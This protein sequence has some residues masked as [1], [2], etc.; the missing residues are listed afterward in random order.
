MISVIIPAYNA[1]TTLPRCI[2]SILAQ[3]YTGQFEI[4][5]VDDGST[6]STLAVA[7]AISSDRLKI[8]TKP[9]GGPASARNTGLL[10]CSPSAQWVTFADSDDY[11]SP[12]WLSTLASLDGDLRICSLLHHHGTETHPHT[13]PLQ[14]RHTFSPLRSSPALASLLPTGLMAS[15]CNKL[16]SLPIIRA[17]SL[18]LRE[19]DLLEDIDFVFTY[20]R[21]CTS[22]SLDTAPLYHYVHRSG[23]VTSH[24]TPEILLNYTRLHSEMLAWFDPALSTDIDEFAFPQYYNLILRLIHAGDHATPR[25]YLRHPMVRRA[26]SSHTPSSTGE[27][28]VMTLM[29]LRLFN[30]V[31]RITRR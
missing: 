17:H 8:V 20:L 2:D 10:H 28:A 25:L 31:S 27:R 23:S 11:V 7:R 18:R 5:V 12:S 19:I 21:H 15:L 14:G 26:F 29:R 6:D 30:I 4:I 9:N 22:A 1:A 13:L 3:D 24:A 16:F